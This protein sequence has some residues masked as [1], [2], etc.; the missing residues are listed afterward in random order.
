MEHPD[1]A[2]AEPILRAAQP[3]QPFD[4]AAARFLRLVSQMRFERGPQRRP[5]MRF[6]PSEVFDSL[7]SQDDLEGHSGQNI[8]RSARPS[9]QPAAAKRPK[10]WFDSDAMAA[11]NLALLRLIVTRRPASV[12][13]LATLAG[14]A[15][16]NLSRTLE[17]AP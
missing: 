12:S 13:E 14:R 11:N 4:P 17:K 2:D 16:P 3:L 7:G 10:R 8:A 1:L 9:N 15:A 5:E 6:D